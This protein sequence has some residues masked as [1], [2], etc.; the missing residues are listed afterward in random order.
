MARFGQLSRSPIIHSS[1]YRNPAPF[2]GKRML[3]VG[4][5]NSGGEIALDLAE[6]WRRCRASVRGP[7]QVLPRDLLGFPIVSWAIFYQYLPAWLV[8]RINA[9]I[10]RL[11]LGR[12]DKL[13]LRLATRD[14]CNDR[15]AW[16]RAADRY[17]HPR[18]NRDGSIRIRSAIDRLT[19]DG[20]MFCDQKTENSTR[21]FL[22]PASVPTY[23][24]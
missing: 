3:V 6:F 24:N 18:Q 13:G 5:G 4:F 20:V 10:L 9:P 23:A 11:A 7:V 12:I 1:D 17:R 8:D 19:S 2:A 16:T 21:L 22:P 15:G 14:R